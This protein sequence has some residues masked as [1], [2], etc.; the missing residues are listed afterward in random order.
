MFTLINNIIDRCFFTAIFI[1]GV[2]LP[3]FMQQYQQRL[4]GHLAEAQSQLNQFEIIAQQHFDGSII[5]M[6]TRY[7][8]NSE[9][10]IVSTGELIERLSLRVEYLST[11]LAQITQSDYLHNVYL[12]IWHLDNEIAKGTA[13]HFSMAIPLELNAIAT[14]GTLAITALILKTITVN[15]IKYPFKKKTV[16]EH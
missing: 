3:E 1:L 9:A 14:G 4:A 5:T 10:A 2:Q 6:V 12:F 8:D 16:I 7:K 15:L 13:E 11:H